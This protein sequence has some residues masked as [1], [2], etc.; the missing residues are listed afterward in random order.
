MA[1]Q[2]INEMTNVAKNGI[3][4]KIMMNTKAGS[5]GTRRLQP[6]LSNH[7]S[8]KLGF[9]SYFLA[10][11]LA[12]LASALASSGAAVVVAISAT[13]PYQGVR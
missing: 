6:W 7:R 2:F 8:L 13:P 1:F 3:W 9:G 11:F 4:V 10:A 5:S 12:A